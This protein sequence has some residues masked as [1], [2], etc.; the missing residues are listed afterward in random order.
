MFGGGKL[1]FPENKLEYIPGIITLIIFIICAL[2]VVRLFRIISERQNLKSK[3]LE[4]EILRNLEGNHK[5]D[6][7]Q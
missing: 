1:Y 6:K 3:Q 4:E 7:E 5:E 2:L